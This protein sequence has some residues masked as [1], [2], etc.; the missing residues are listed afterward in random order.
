MVQPISIIY[1]NLL[2]FF[3]MPVTF[4]ALYCNIFLKYVLKSYQSLLCL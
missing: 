2:T 3:E 1:L 4:K